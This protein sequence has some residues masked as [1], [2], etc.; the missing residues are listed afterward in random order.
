VCKRSFP[1]LLKNT[2]VSSTRLAW[3]AWDYPDNCSRL[4]CR[5]LA[6]II[7]IA[8]DFLLHLAQ[9]HRLF[10]N[11]VFDISSNACC[12]YPKMEAML[13]STVYSK[14]PSG[15][16]TTEILWSLRRQVIPKGT[17][18]YSFLV[19]KAHARPL[20]KKFPPDAG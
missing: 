11:L 7:I 18:T 3:N 10:V 6:L 1:L 15:K 5:Q 16:R 4:P 13:K 2:H 8:C 20:W 17:V 12:E 9:F 19:G 14:R